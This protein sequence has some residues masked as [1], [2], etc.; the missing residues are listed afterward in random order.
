M[1]RTRDGLCW[2]GIP[3]SGSRPEPCSKL[4]LQ[5]HPLTSNAPTKC[6]S[7]KAETMGLVVVSDG[8]EVLLVHKLMPSI[9]YQRS[10][11]Q[12]VWRCRS[13]AASVWSAPHA[14]GLCLDPAEST[15]I[16]WTDPEMDS[17]LAISFQEKKGCAHVWWVPDKEAGCSVAPIS[18]SPQHWAAAFPRGLQGT[19]ADCSGGAT[20]G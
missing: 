11:G 16:T 14:G 17:D 19:A 4:V 12:W 7:Q 5:A 10:A 8:G 9:N 13:G 6:L 1:G 15:I 2:A 20:S 18:D 3:G